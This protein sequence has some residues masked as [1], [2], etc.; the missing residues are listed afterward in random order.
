MGQRVTQL[1]YQVIQFTTVRC[2][3]STTMQATCTACLAPRRNCLCTATRLFVLFTVIVGRAIGVLPCALLRGLSRF[4][5]RHEPLWRAGRRGRWR[6]GMRWDEGAWNRSRLRWD[7]LQGI[8]LVLQTRCH[9]GVLIW[10][11]LTFTESRRGVQNFPSTVRSLDSSGRR[12]VLQPAHV[13]GALLEWRRN[14]RQSHKSHPWKAWFCFPPGFPA[15][16]NLARERRQHCYQ[17]HRSDTFV[18]A[19]TSSDCAS[20]ILVWGFTTTDAALWTAASCRCPRLNCRAVVL[21][22]RRYSSRAV[23]VD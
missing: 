9:A 17:L 3:S 2:G 19:H 14:G 20:T 22:H 16:G 1:R 8:D 4:R 10:L 18:P 11:Q 6:R 15:D 5:R 12:S 13:R 7:K 23:G 21:R